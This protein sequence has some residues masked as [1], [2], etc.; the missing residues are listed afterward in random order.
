[1][2]G[3]A[4]GRPPLRAMLRP[5]GKCTLLGPGSIAHVWVAFRCLADSVS[6]LMRGSRLLKVNAGTWCHF[7]HLSSQ[8]TA[9]L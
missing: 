7:A 6:E 1:M 3:R 4:W 2:I 9:E 5:K 8:I